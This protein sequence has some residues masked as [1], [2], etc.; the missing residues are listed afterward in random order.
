M[1]WC[2]ALNELRTGSKLYTVLGSACAKAQGMIVLNVG[3]LWL[4]QGKVVG[5]LT[6]GQ[7][8]CTDHHHSIS[9]MLQGRICYLTQWNKGTCIVPLVL[10][11]PIM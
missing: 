3:S 2:R 10:N 8:T 1:T 6:R 7:M 11:N 9:I 4:K 5:E